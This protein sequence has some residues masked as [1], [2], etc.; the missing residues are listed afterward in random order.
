MVEG[1]FRQ[2]CTRARAL[3]GSAEDGRPRLV[4]DQDAYALH[5]DVAID[6]E[7]F[8]ALT[9]RAKDRGPESAEDLRQALSLVRGE[10]LEDCGYRWIDPMI[11]EVVRARIV[12]TAA[13]LAD[14]SSDDPFTAAWAAC[15][16]LLA[17]P[18]AEPL[19]RT[20]M[21]ASHNLGHTRSIHL[22]YQLCEQA[23][24]LLD[25]TPHEQTT[26]LYRDLTGPTKSPRR[27]NR[28]PSQDNRG[29]Q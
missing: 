1:Y 4:Y 14:L 13:L 6:W 25:L 20:L 7:D 3:L 17:D 28:L 23:L 12:E 21:T 24:A 10:P 26:T 19:H 11:I 5:P 29:E 2:T 16:G 15:R 22:A 18:Y 8:R 9:A 27:D